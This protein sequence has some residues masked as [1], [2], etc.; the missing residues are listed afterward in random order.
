MRRIVKGD[1]YESMAPSLEGIL[2]DAPPDREQRVREAIQRAPGRMPGFR[3]NLEA[4]ICV[5]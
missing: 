2:K 5:S 4:H 3:Y 1:T